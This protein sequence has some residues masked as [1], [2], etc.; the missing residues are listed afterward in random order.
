MEVTLMAGVTVLSLGLVVAS[1]G[2]AQAKEGA[3]ESAGWI[4]I[5]LGGLVTLVAA[6]WAGW[7]WAI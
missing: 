5:V 1:L 2:R 3:I 6:L 7:S 4:L